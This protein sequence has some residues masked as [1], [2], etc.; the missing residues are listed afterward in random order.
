V[1]TPAGDV[2]V[3]PTGRASGRGAYVCRDAACIDKAI[4]KGAFSRALNTKLPAGLIEA[5]AGSDPIHDTIEG[6]TRG[7]E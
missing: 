3:D 6:G 5:L 2:I 1:R 4:T 7:Q